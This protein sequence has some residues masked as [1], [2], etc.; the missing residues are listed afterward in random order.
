VNTTGT[1]SYSCGAIE[2][3]AR[4]PATG[5]AVANR[6]A[7]W[8][9][10]D[11]WPRDGEIDTMEGRS[12]ESCSYWPATGTGRGHRPP[13]A[14]TGRHTFGHRWEPGRITWYYDGQ[15]VHT[16]TSGVVGSPHCLVRQNPR[17][18]FGGPTPTPADLRVDYVRPWA[19]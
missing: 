10:G 11:F 16:E 15:P 2:S 3:R 19:K 14:R 1:F 9:T 18:S 5:G 17:G 4:V 13:G 7:L 8:D 12:G 6:P